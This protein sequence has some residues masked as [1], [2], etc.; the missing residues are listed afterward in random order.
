MTHKPLEKLDRL[1]SSQNLSYD[2][3]TGDFT[4]RWLL[5]RSLWCEDC[6]S[7][8]LERAAHVLLTFPMC[9]SLYLI[10]CSNLFPSIMFQKHMFPASLWC[11]SVT[12]LC[13]R[14]WW[15]P[16]TVPSLCWQHTGRIRKTRTWL[17]QLQGVIKFLRAPWW[18]SSL[19]WARRFCRRACLHMVQAELLSERHWSKS[20]K[21]S[22]AVPLCSK[23]GPLRTMASRRK[24]FVWEDYTAAISVLQ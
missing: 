23:V 22:F 14:K 1:L 20:G 12:L 4:A 7:R 9:L 17:S 5:K 16:H 18:L 3:C 13:F 11:Q 15:S 19:Q 6:E 8:V 2:F 24:P 10:S 21:M